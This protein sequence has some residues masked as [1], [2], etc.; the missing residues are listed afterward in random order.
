MSNGSQIPWRKVRHASG[1]PLVKVGFAGYYLHIRPTR[2]HSGSKAL[3]QRLVLTANEA[4]ELAYHIR[5]V[6]D[7]VD[8]GRAPGNYR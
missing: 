3:E 8:Q 4:R 2:A 7:Q 5:V 6:A 1:T